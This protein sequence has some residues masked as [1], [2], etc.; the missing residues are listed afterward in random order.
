MK[1]KVKQYRV[2]K[3]NSI[4]LGL[5]IANAE[6]LTGTTMKVLKGS[7]NKH[8]LHGKFKIKLHRMIGT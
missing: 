5:R 6:S 4:G 1:K 7:R 2:G 8:N 3:F